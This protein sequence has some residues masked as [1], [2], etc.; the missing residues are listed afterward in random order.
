MTYRP[1]KEEYKPRTREQKLGYLMEECGEVL[2]AAGKLLRWGPDSVNPELPP[3]AQE[4]NRDWL[5]RELHDLERAIR[6][7][8]AEFNYRPTRG[9]LAPQAGGESS[10]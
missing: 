9:A 10:G 3:E 4:T 2:A 8:R 6:F 1:M 7:I 5:M